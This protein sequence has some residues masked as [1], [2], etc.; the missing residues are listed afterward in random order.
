M[1]RVSDVAM[2]I[3]RF[4]D[5]WQR[6]DIDALMSLVSDDC[7]YDASIGPGPGTEYA[8]KAEV[9]RGF[10]EMLAYDEKG[11]PPG[12]IVMVDGPRAV[13]LWTVRRA[14]ATGTIV[15]VRGCD[16]FEVADGLIRRKDAFRKS[17]A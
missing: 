7:V 5:A 9:R 10:V 3:Q 6:A 1:S 4:D 15:A 14:T 16:V 11:G 12:R 13:V 17:F 2:I 8:G